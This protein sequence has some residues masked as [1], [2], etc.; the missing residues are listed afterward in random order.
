MLKEFRSAHSSY[1][2]LLEEEKKKI[3]LND[4]EKQALHISDDIEK[5]KLQVKQKKRAVKVMDD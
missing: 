4:R 1:K 2:I 5:L 3:S